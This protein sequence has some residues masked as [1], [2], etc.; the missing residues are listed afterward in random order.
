[1]LLLPVRLTPA[2]NAPVMAV[3]V[4]V[5]AYSRARLRTAPLAS[6]TAVLAVASSG[7]GKATFSTVHRSTE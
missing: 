4:T 2:T 6:R 7:V 5:V 1:M 3:N